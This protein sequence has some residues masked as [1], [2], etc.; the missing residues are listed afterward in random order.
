MISNGIYVVDKARIYLLALAEI[1][2]RLKPYIALVIYRSI[3]AA[4]SQL[5]PK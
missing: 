5:R 3:N 1:R 4:A 2:F